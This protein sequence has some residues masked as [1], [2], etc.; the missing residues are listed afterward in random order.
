[1]AKTAWFNQKDNLPKI[2]SPSL[3]IIKVNGDY[4]HYIPKVMY[5]IMNGDDWVW[6]ADE[7]TTTSNINRN[8]ILYAKD[9]VFLW[10]KI[11]YF[12]SPYPEAFKR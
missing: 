2:N 5:R 9:E 12:P 10:S 6:F 8:K 11:P 3:C 4:E 1:M 7:Y